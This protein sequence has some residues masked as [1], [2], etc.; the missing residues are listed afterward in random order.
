MSYVTICVFNEVFQS[1]SVLQHLISI[2]WFFFYAGVNVTDHH[3]IFMK[4][5][6]VFQEKVSPHVVSLT[7]KDCATLKAL[8]G[9]VV[10]QLMG[11]EYIVS[12]L[13]LNLNNPHTTK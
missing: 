4:L 11:I 9:T 8:M 2:I 5:T 12:Y 6:S 10:S 7:S 13:Q 1:E 3:D